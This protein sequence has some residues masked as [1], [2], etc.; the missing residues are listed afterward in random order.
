MKA[1]GILHKD[2]CALI[3][4]LGHGDVI[5]V[6]DAGFAIPKDVPRIELAIEKNVPKSER[7]LE[8]LQA[9]LIIEKYELAEEMKEV[10]PVQLQKYR[11]I[12]T[13][14][15]IVEAFVPHAKL[16]GE[17]AQKA[18]AVI[19]TGSF[20]P[21]GSIALYPAIDA[22]EWY[23]AEGVAVPEFYRERLSK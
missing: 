22:V 20:Q 18:K 1:K 10:N 2:L 9:E 15:T 21:Y 5:I 8:L 19:R 16:S 11:E 12:Y 17:I 4:S 6:C 14:T 3:G 13:D 23:K 7:I